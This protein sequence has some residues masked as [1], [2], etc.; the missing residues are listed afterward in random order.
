MR[1]DKSKFRGNYPHVFTPDWVENGFGK[2]CNSPQ[3]SNYQI[4]RVSRI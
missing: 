2:L 4:H 1:N 3:I